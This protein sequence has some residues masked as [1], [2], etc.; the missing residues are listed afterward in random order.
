MPLKNFHQ[1]LLG[2]GHGIITD[3]GRGR[4]PVTAAAHLPGNGADIYQRSVAAG[5]QVYFVFHQGE[6]EYRVQIVYFHHFLDQKRQIVNILVAAHAGDHHI[7]TVDAVMFGCVDQFIKEIDLAGI[8]FF[9]HQVG[10]G[11]EIGAF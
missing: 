8:H 3:G 1:S 6:G 11:I 10:Y 2:L 7:H 4:E 5:C 9:R